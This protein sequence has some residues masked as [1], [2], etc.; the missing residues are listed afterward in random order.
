MKE[1]R[2]VTIVGMGA[3]GIMY[4]KAFADCLGAGAVS[5]VMDQQ[6]YEK[7]RG[8]SVLCNGVST[9]FT[10]VRAEEAVPSDLVLV[11][12][13]GTG[14]A[15]AISTMRRCV[16]PETVLISVLNG[17]SSEEVLASAFGAEK[18]VYAVAQGM[19]A[20]KFG[21]ELTFSQRGELRIGITK[22][23]RQDNLSALEQLLDRTG[24]AWVEEADILRRLWGKLM[25]NVGINQTCMAYGCTYG[26]ALAP[27]EAN[28][29]LVAAMREVIAVAQAEGIALTEQDLHGYLALLGTLRPEGTP[30]MGQDRI[31][32]R[33]S[34]VELFSGTIRQLAR[35]HNLVVPTNDFLYQRIREIEAG[36]PP[37]EK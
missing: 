9:S 7:Y 10:L 6:R 33:P 18:I 27:G 1:L 16:G 12:V 20:I 26:D 29:T 15:G 14:L 5:F 19:D 13:K 2:T 31:K 36:Y 22:T 23:G 37:E 24:I 3:L 32:R 25:L 8:K 4:G 21:S 30:S 17:I 11:A 28:R 34:E 35:R